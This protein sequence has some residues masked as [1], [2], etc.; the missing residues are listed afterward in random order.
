MH[1]ANVWGISSR[2]P[3]IAAALS[4]PHVKSYKS[5]REK[6]QWWMKPKFAA[7]SNACGCIFRDQAIQFNSFPVQPRP[8]RELK[9]VL[10]GCMHLGQAISR[11]GSL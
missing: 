6:Q 2:V 7:Q 10:P 11:E 8:K 9:M 5:D 1:P 4:H 3:G